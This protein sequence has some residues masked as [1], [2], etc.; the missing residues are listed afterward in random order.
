MSSEAEREEDALVAA[1]S[2]G[3]LETPVVLGTGETS[4]VF[5]LA[6]PPA[7]RS[8]ALKVVAGGAD[9][10]A[11]AAEAHFVRRC[12]HPF[13][14]RCHGS[15]GPC[16]LLE[17]CV[18]S[19]D[20]LV[21]RNRARP[22]PVHELERAGQ[23]W[24]SQIA[25][26]LARIHAAGV[27]HRDIKPSN[28]LIHGDGTIRIA[29]FG[30]ACENGAPAPAPFAGTPHTTAPELLAG[31]AFDSS[32]DVWSLGCVAMEL[33]FNVGPFRPLSAQEVLAAQRAP[34]A[35][36]PVTSAPASQDL[37]RRML[38]FNPKERI[39]ASAALCHPA[40]APHVNA[41]YERNP[42]V[43]RDTGVT[44]DDVR[45]GMGRSLSSLGPLPAH[46][47][48]LPSASPAAPPLFMWWAPSDRSAPQ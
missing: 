6:V 34:A 38:A 9:A 29:D 39:R 19:V 17:M 18:D 16:V 11:A 8:V 25:L 42:L 46:P 27:V 31:G 24:A 30:A 10:A 2:E 23:A 4:R 48:P 13:V 32:A 43:L 15:R 20:R 45:A 5:R 37:L 44:I 26:G 21:E 40:L 33:M 1:A 28:L 41:L 22:S 36:I 47:P 35:T 14:V 3:V 12:A 7:G